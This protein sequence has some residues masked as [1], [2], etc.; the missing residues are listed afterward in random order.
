MIFYGE[1]LQQQHDVAND[2]E[3]SPHRLALVGVFRVTIPQK[4]IFSFVSSFHTSSN[5]KTSCCALTVL[6]ALLAFRTG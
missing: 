5:N 6:G 4:N 3:P 2:A 1:S